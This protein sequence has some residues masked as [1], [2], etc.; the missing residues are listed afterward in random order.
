MRSAVVWLRPSHFAIVAVCRHKRLEPVGRIV[1]S[2]KLRS[3]ECRT[4]RMSV[5]K[6]RCGARPS[7]LFRW[8]LDALHVTEDQLW[9]TDRD[10]T[11]IWSLFAHS[12][13]PSEE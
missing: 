3:Y 12:S 5:D 7:R 11:V 13:L 8:L 9:G 6:Q 4:G 1:F 10:C 2:R